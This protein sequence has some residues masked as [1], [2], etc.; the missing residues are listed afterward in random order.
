MIQKQRIGVIVAL[1]IFGGLFVFVY[2]QYIVPVSTDNT[3]QIE[4]QKTDVS[5]SAKKAAE[6]ETIDE[7]AE[8]ITG[9]AEADLSALDDE[10]SGEGADIESDSES[11]TNFGTAYDEES[12]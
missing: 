1:I 10:A 4:R 5:Q 7:M 2:R 3:L 12:L 9:E 11:V 6:P 8:S